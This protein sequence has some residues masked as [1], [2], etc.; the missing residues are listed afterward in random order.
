ME[1]LKQELDARVQIPGLTNAWVMPIRTRIDMLATGIKTPVGIKVAGPELATIESIGRELE[2]LLGDLPGTA[3]VFSERV[4]GGRYIRIDIDRERAARFGLGVSDVQSVVAGAVGGVNVTTTVEGAERYPVNLRY[5]QALRDSPEA[6]AQL[7]LLTPSGQHITLDAVARIAVRDGPAGI[8][9]ENAR[10]NGWT[11]IDLE[12]VDIGSWIGAARRLLDEKLSLPPGYS[13]TWAGQFEYLERAR[14]RLGMVV[15]LTLAIIVLLLYLNFR[16]PAPVLLLLTTLPLSL[17]GGVWLLYLLDYNL[18]VAVAVGMIAL[19]GVSV[20]TGVIMLACLESAWADAVGDGQKYTGETGRDAAALIETGALQRVRPVLMTATATV[21]GLL[22]ILLG[23][24]T[25]SEVMSR[26]AAPMV[27]GML[28][29]IVFTLLVLPAVF[30]LWRRRD[31][32]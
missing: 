8:K 14:E 19:L 24:G 26:L 15:P 4:A 22:P 27:G 6:L 2:T 9:S 30:L 11:Y 16:R 10:V 1:K 31:P 13:I 5:P 17:T 3:S 23:S 32:D 18:S 29:T 25:G 7:P 21:A 12:G 28:T 20:E